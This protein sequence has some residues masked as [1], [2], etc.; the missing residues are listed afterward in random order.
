MKIM[1]LS[2]MVGTPVSEPLMAE[3]IPDSAILKDNKPLFLPRFSSVWSIEV[4]VAF[5]VCRLGKNIGQKFASRYYDAFTVALR[6]VPED[7]KKVAG[8]SAVA[9]SFDNALIIGE[10]IPV[11]KLPQTITVSTGNWS[12]DLDAQS[13][14]IDEAVKNLSRYFTFKIGDMVIPASVGHSFPVAIDSNVSISVCSCEIMNF[15]IK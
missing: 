4:A 11:E 6:L 13:I 15:K 5:R 3:I 2:R 8:T 9:T 12:V 14:L 10:W 1:A 7:L